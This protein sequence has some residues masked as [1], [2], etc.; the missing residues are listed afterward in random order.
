MF[1]IKIKFVDC[2]ILIKQKQNIMTIYNEITEKL[3]QIDN[4]Y[5]RGIYTTGEYYDLLKSIDEKLKDY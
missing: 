1:I 5:Y 3:K 4:D 2:G